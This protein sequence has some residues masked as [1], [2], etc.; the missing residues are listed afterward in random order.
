MT[1]TIRLIDCFT[2]YLTN[3]KLVNQNYTLGDPKISISVLGYTMKSVC[4]PPSKI[5]SVFDYT[6]AIVI[7]NNSVNIY[8]N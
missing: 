4:Y 3:S 2:D 6:P 7:A 8:S 1:W 5:I